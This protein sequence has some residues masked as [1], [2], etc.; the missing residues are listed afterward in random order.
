MLYG[1]TTDPKE[2]ASVPV[3]VEASPFEDETET[4]D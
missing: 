2:D 3:T 4:A 1:K